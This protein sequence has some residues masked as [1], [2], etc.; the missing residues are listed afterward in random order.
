MVHAKL[1]VHRKTSLIL[2]SGH[3]YQGSVSKAQLPH[4]F[5]IEYVGKIPCL[6]TYIHYLIKMSLEKHIVLKFNLMNCTYF[7]QVGKTHLS[8]TRVTG[9]RG[10][11]L[12]RA[13]SI[14]KTAKPAS[15]QVSRSRGLSSTQVTR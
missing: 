8:S 6:Y 15:I 11:G 9:S 13:L 2:E 3:L 10:R 12:A 5:G 14:I 7:C 4:G 1:C